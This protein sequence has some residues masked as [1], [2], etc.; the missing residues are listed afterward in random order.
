MAHFAKNSSASSERPPWQRLAGP[1]GGS[2]GGGERACGRFGG[3]GVINP[4]QVLAQAPG[5]ASGEL[6]AEPRHE[7]SPATQLVRRFC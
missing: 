6:D 2:W 3:A 1:T 4:T 7:K 5:R